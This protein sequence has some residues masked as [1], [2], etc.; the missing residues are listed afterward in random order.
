MYLLEAVFGNLGTF[1]VK[2]HEA[3]LWYDGQKQ[4]A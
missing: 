4:V 3:S 1:K 2:E